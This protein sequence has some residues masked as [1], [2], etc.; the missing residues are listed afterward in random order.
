MWWFV[1]LCDS[2]Q[3]CRSTLSIT[4]EAPTVFCSFP[5]TRALSINKP[6]A[7]I[8]VHMCLLW[9]LRIPGRLKSRRQ[10]QLTKHLI[11]SSCI[12]NSSCWSQFSNF[13]RTSVALVG[14]FLYLL[15][16]FVSLEGNV[17][18]CDAHWSLI[19]V[20]VCSCKVWQWGVNSVS[21]CLNGQFHLLKFYSCSLVSIFA[22]HIHC[23]P[24]R[25]RRSIYSWPF[26]GSQKKVTSM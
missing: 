25:P 22:A 10:T 4:G 8:S 17:V 14:L 11:E 18:L 20:R 16:Q 7:V 26:K 3:A 15:H 12:A 1:E 21:T 23:W 5:F 2:N 13:C 19:L 24:S 9:L 6:G